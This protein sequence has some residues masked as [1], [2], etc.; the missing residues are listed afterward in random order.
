MHHGFA[1]AWFRYIEDAIPKEALQD[2]RPINR[3]YID[4]D[5]YV[6]SK[7]YHMKLLAVLASDFHEVLLLDADNLALRDPTYLFS[8][9]SYIVTGQDLSFNSE[10]HMP[11]SCVRRT[12]CRSLNCLNHFLPSS[13]ALC[14]GL[15]SGEQT[16]AGTNN[17]M[18]TTL[19]SVQG[20]QR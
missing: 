9:Q 13:Q 14:F 7:P 10:R 19:V 3:G 12:F 17:L 1:V 16:L 11:V 6:H 2:L 4:G 8:W 18:R 15:I 5:G 20:R